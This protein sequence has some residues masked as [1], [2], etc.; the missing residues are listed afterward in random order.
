MEIMHIYESFLM[1]IY[2]V[3]HQH[4]M[5]ATRAAHRPALTLLKH[6]KAKLLLLLQ[7]VIVPTS[8]GECYSVHFEQ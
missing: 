3:H 2:F 1:S 5:T 4:L 8:L 7:Q 6:L